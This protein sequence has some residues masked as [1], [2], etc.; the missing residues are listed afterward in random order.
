M[1]FPLTF[2]DLSSAFSA[3]KETCVNAAAAAVAF[4]MMQT[5]VV[6][7]CS[8]ECS[9]GHGG[10]GLEAEKVV[11]AIARGVQRNPVVQPVDSLVLRWVPGDVGK[12]VLQSKICELILEERILLESVGYASL[13]CG[14]Q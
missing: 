6:R 13:E 1:H 5:V 12:L 8:P 4:D 14:F 2:F 7:T 9:G 3:S 10:G 11:D